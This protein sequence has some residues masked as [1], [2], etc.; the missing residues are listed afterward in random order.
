MTMPSM[1]RHRIHIVTGGQTGAD[2]AAFD[3]ALEYGLDYGGWV[4]RGRQDETGPIPKRFAGLRETESRDGTERTRR[5]VRTSDALLVVS[6][7][8][9]RDG[10][11]VALQE[12]TDTA[13]PSLSLDL[14]GTPPAAAALALVRWIAAQSADGGVMRLNVAGARASQDG[15]IYDATYQLL[16][17]GLQ[18][19]PEAPPP[20]KAPERPDRR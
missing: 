5:N 19:E 4:P 3:V 6:H 8:P 1:S 18:L 7:G 11:L 13:K 14:V 16:I 15:A 10:T 17:A 9:V 12:A 2:R 20:G